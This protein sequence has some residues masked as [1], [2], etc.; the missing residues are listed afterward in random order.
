MDE[1][2]FEVDE[3]FPYVEEKFLSVFKN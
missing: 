3:N 1:I 2:L